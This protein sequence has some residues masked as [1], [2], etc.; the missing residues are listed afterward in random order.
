MNIIGTLITSLFNLVLLPF[1]RTN[2]TLGLIALSILAGILFAFVFKWVSNARA[3]RQAKD[4]LKARI[5]EMRIYQDDPVLILKG[6]VGTLRYNLGYL[7]VLLKP[8]VILLVPLVVIWMQLD[9]RYSH[10]PLQ[11]G[12]RTL[13]QVQLAEGVDPFEANVTLSTDGG[14]VAD[15]RQ[16][17]IADTREIG[18]RLRVDR[19]GTHDVT[20]SADDQTYTF[21]I[22][23]EESYQL[24]G[25][26]RD[27]TWLEPLL[28]PG[29]PRI[30]SGSPFSK[31]E[32]T[33]AGASY[34][35]FFW[36]A[37]W[38]AVFLVYLS[39]AAFVL[40]FVIKFEI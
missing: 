11:A 26:K 35:L 16:V 36:H 21:P 12:S 7:R 10:R 34:P 39:L 13:L 31:V 15:S 28:H 18:W 19:P 1:G 17:R 14:V 6:F 20:L 27:T 8:M 33:Y 23:A 9:E 25:R 4:R 2:H 40:K 29:M 38:W 37:P 22:V 32:L 24:L 5:L 30:P 3:V